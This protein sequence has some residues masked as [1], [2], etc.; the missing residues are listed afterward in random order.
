M[1]ENPEQNPPA[2]PVPP[3]AGWAPP[4]APVYGP[5]PG[6]PTSGAAYAPPPG[7]ARVPPLHPQ[8]VVPA[9]TGSP[10]LGIVALVLALLAAVGASLL[11][12]GA[13]AA[14]AAGAGREIALNASPDLDL[15]VLAPVRVWV[16]VG[17]VSF[18][19]G[20]VLGVWALAQGT[21]AIVRRRG[22]GVGIAAVVVAA[23]GPVIFFT[24]LQIGL[25]AGFGMSGLSG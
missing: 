16:L 18:W 21:V 8:P 10:A 12:A 2:P 5:P 13:G 22:R 24:A 1:S 4:S 19:I 15:S 11:A 7:S 9:A 6:Y 17:E 3:P 25:A 14:I 23:L 20:T